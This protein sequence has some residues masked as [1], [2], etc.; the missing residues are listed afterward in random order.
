[1]ARNLVGQ[2]GWPERGGELSV[3]K[4]RLLPWQW[5]RWSSDMHPV[6]HRDEVPRWGTWHTTA[7]ARRWWDLSERPTAGG[8]GTASLAT[9][10]AQ[11]DQTPRF[12][13]GCAYLT[14]TAHESQ[15]A[16]D[17]RRRAE[18]G[19]GIF[20]SLTLTVP[21]GSSVRWTW[22]PNLELNFLSISNNNSYQ[23]LQQ[24]CRAICHLQYCYMV[25]PKKANRSCFKLGLKLMSVHCQSD[26]RL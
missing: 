2:C 4:K 25:L 5:L 7:A 6:S 8:G 15:W 19:I 1:V 14:A 13:L 20:F 24:N 9:I 16:T 26:F 22:Q 10:R 17:Q 18:G 12:L 21:W 23:A 3:W 11:V